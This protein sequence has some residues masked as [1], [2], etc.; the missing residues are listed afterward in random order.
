MVGVCEG[1]GGGKGCWGWSVN[2]LANFKGGIKM[3][4]QVGE[5]FSAGPGHRA[6]SKG[7]RRGCPVTLTCCRYVSLFPSAPVMSSLWCPLGGPGSQAVDSVGWLG[8]IGVCK[9]EEP[10]S[11]EDPCARLLSPALSLPPPS[12]PPSPGL[13]NNL[14]HKLKTNKL[15][16]PLGVL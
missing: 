6:S 16:S 7:G 11:P 4:M 2:A 10:S 13:S 5:K 3:H 8:G 15:S 14:A 1:E 12:L 9:L